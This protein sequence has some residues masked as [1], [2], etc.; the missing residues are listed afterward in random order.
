V[1]PVEA[2]RVLA[3][4]RAAADAHVLGDRLDEVHG[5]GDVGGRARQDAGQCPPAEAGRVTPAQ[6]DDGQ[7]NE[8]SYGTCPAVRSHPPSLRTPH[9]GRAAVRMLDIART[10]SGTPDSLGRYFG[11]AG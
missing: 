9:A 8:G 4:G 10:W 1:H 3:D 2:L 7:V 5:P 11:A 6:V